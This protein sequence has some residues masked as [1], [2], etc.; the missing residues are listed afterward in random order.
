[1]EQITDLEMQNLLEMTRT[2]MCRIERRVMLV[3]L[4]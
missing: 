4:R 3:L 2:L 1:M